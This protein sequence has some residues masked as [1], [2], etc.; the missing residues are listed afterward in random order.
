[1]DISHYSLR[2]YL[3]IVKD[4]IERSCYQRKPGQVTQLVN[5]PNCKY[6]HYRWVDDYKKNHE[7]G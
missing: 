3:R 1:M 5:C 4:R 7:D 2:E 6:A